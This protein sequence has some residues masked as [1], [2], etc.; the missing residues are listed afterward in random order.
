MPLSDFFSNFANVLKYFLDTIHWKSLT[1]GMVL[2]EGL[3]GAAGKRGITASRECRKMSSYDFS[4]HAPHGSPHATYLSQQ[5]HPNNF[6]TVIQ[7]CSHQYLRYSHRNPTTILNVLSG[8]MSSP[9]SA[10]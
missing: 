7:S 10:Q 4:A 9:Y 1:Y 3:I 5:D 6:S 2:E 8:K